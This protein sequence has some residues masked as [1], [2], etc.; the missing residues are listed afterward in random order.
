MQSI[1]STTMA[2]S[3]RMLAVTVEDAEGWLEMQ[4]YVNFSH[5]GTEF[6]AN[7]RGQ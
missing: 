5:F 7:W 4:L 1:L 2:Y 3:S 6:V